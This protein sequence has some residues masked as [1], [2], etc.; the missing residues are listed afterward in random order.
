MVNFL[1]VVYAHSNSYKH[2][3]LGIVYCNIKIFE[4]IVDCLRLSHADMFIIILYN[5]W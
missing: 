5:N 3:G 2:A 4:M 1:P